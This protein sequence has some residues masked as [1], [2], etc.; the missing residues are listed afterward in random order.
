[1]ETFEKIKEE[2]ITI[3][4][5]KGAC[6]DQ[7]EKASNSQNFAE[8]LEVVKNNSNWCY[9]AGI[10]SDNI[11]SK[12][13]V[14][15]L[16]ESGIYY[17]QKGI[18]QSTG[19]CVYHSS[20][21]KHYDSSTSEHYDSST[22]EHYDSS[23]SEHYHSSTSEHY[24]SSTSKHYSSSTSKHY[25]SSTSEHYHSSTSKHYDSSTSEH[26]DSST[27]EHYHSSTS[28]HYSSSTSKH[29]DSS[30]SEHYHSSTS[31]HY[32]SSTSKHYSS[33]TFGSVYKL[34]DTSVIHD[35]AIVRERLTDKVYCKKNAFEIVL[36]N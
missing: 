28:K 4:K 33:S 8:L 35:Q 22:S 13:P 25:D 16:N 10:L 29:Y 17:N 3:A 20:T 27:S 30:T 24:G 32:G 11:L 5:E 31:E 7:F 18:R 15:T 6:A 36:I 14:E 1:M 2:I 19:F 26:Y 23:T 21:S 34:S 9:N 12:I